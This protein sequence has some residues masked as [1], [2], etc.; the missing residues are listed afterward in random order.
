MIR[1]PIFTSEHDQLRESVRRF[2]DGEIRPH[3]PEWEAA[4]FFPDEVFRRCG[5]LGFLG[6]HYPERWGGSAGDLAAG[7]VFIEEL[8]RCGAGAI[9]M[10][11]SVQTHMAT[12]A[13]AEFGTDEQRERWLAPAIAGTKIGAIAITEPDAGSDVAA[14]R[15]TAVRDGD[16]WRVNGRKMFI[17]N[18]ARAHFLTLVVK[19]DAAAG[20][21]GVS[22]F[23]VDTSLAGVTVSRRLE[24]L[25]MHASD[26]A[27]IALDDVAVPHSDL[28]GLEPG[29]G[30]A[31]LMWQ[32]QYERLA[33]AAASVGHAGRTLDDTIAY[34]R[35][36]HTFG[37]PIAQHQVIAHKLADAATELEAARALLYS[38][39]WAVVQGDYPVTEISMCKKF[40]AQVQNRLVDTCVQVWGGAGYLEET[41]IPRA[42]RDARLQRIGG[43][44][45][46]IMNEVIA[47]N[48]F[49]RS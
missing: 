15:T 9:P 46:E 34:A 21:Q 48:L 8:A 13:L 32:L 7:L 43:G 10:A 25:G 23:V 47:K 14:I 22:L 2:V 4:G 26:T 39:A 38:T 37:R 6:L 3:V 19:T 16:V 35:E 5:E 42:F 27:E 44:T 36:R 41:G 24:K 40:C 17:T 12:P 45:D 49:G 20:H 31:Q 11:V 18:G 1:Y 29:R 28:I 30:F 33:G